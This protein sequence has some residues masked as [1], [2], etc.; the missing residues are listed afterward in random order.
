MLK[1]RTLYRCMECREIHD[2]ED[3]AQ[4]CCRPAISEL[5]E[6]PVCKGIHDE[7]E[8]ANLC[9]GAD[10]IKCPLCAR[11]YSS[12]SLSF[13]AITVAG[14]CTTCNPMFTV[15][16]QL[17]IQDLHYKNTGQREHVHD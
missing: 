4:D 10:A 13:Q 15:D 6:C 2:D 16:Q 5:Y 17:A 12:I 8:Q 11:D 7:E 1:V 14:H 9:C 3:E